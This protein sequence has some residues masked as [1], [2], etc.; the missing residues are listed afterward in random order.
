MRSK[1]DRQVMGPRWERFELLS[2]QPTHSVGAGY[3]RDIQKQVKEY[4][5]LSSLRFSRSI[6]NH[7]ATSECQGEA[8]NNRYNSALNIYL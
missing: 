4:I 5:S 1:P 6:T 8:G 2:R 3:R 7:A